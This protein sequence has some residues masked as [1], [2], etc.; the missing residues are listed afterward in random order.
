MGRTPDIPD[1][2]I[3][4]PVLEL[5][6]MAHIHPAPVLAHLDLVVRPHF[7]PTAPLLK[8]VHGTGSKHPFPDAFALIGPQGDGDLILPVIDDFEEPTGFIAVVFG[9]RGTRLIGKRRPSWR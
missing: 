7:D 4:D 2:H 9:M 6:D 1:T 3:P 8:G 5:P